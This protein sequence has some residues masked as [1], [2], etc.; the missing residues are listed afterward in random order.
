MV[1]ALAVSNEGKQEHHCRSMLLL[2]F[3]LFDG[4][5]TGRGFEFQTRVSNNRNL[6]ASRADKVGAY[7]ALHSCRS[8]GVRWRHETSLG[9]IGLHKAKVD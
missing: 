1:L 7:L 2:F 4:L 3:S 9:V 8:A 6:R 5:W